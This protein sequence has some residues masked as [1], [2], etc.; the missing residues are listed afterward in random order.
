MNVSYA[1]IAVYVVR[2]TPTGSHEFLQL[3][4]RQGD[5][6][7]GTWQTVRGTAHPGET[8]WQ[9]AL[10]E[11]HEETGL[12]PAEFYKLSGMETFYLVHNE[13][14]YHV[15]SF[16]AIV[17]PSAAVV[18]NEEHD[19]HR[20][21]PRDTAAFHFMWPSERPLLAEVCDEILDDGATKPYLRIDTPL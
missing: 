14:T 20:W 11:L 9:A 13:T 16:C 17:S 18:L 2:S 5:Y 8:A 21:L 1:M 6:M 4:R 7:G 10:R 19:Q 12:T 3:R 15:A